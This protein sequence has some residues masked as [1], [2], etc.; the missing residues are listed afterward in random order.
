MK[1]L[2]A[3]VAAL[4]VGA[5]VASAQVPRVLSYQGIL[6]DSQGRILPDGEYTL[7]I[8]LYDRVD[9][10]EPIYV[11]EQRVVSVRGVVNV[12]IGTVEPLPWKLSFDR[13]YYV[14]MSVNGSEELRPRTMLTAVPYALRAE[15]AAVADVAKTVSPEA[16]KGVQIQATPDGPAGGDLTGTYP[17]PYI[18][19]NKVTTGKIATAAVTTDKIAPAA[20]TAAKLNQMGA[21]T[22]EYLR[23]NGTQWDP[24]PVSTDAWALVGNA[25]TSSNFLGTTNAQP[26]A[27][28]TNNL[29]RMR[30]DAS[31]NV[32]IGTT[33]PS[34]R[35]H[36]TATSNPV[37]IEGLGTDNTLDNV[38]V[39]DANGV[40]K[41][42][43]ATSLSGTIGWSLTGNSGTNPS[44]NFLGTTDGVD[45]AVRT[46]NT[47]R[48]RVTS[49]GYVGI[50]TT[51]PSVMLDVSGDANIAGNNTV[52]GNISVSGNATI[53]GNLSTNGNA[54][55]GDASSDVL[56]VNAQIASSLIP[57]T[58]N[59]FDLG[60]NLLRWRNGWFSGTVT[61][62]GLTLVGFTPGSVL[63]IGTGGALSQ[64]NANF[65]WDNT[66]VRLGIGTNTPSAN[67]HV[68]GNATVTTNTSIG[69]NLS[70][71]GNA[72]I[73][74]N[75][76]LGD[77]TTDNVT[78]TA[79]VNSHIHPSTD[80]TYDLGASTLRW[81]DGWFSG[82][83]TSQNATVTSLTPG[84]VVFAGTGGALSQNNAN[85]FW[86]N[87]N[88][89]LGIG[90]AT[91]AYP[92]HVHAPT[93]NA[94]NVTSTGTT[95]AG[96][97]FD[98]NSSGGRRF[99]I[100][101]TGTGAGVGANKLGFF[102]ETG[103]Y[104]IAVME[105]T[106]GNVGI[107]PSAITGPQARLHVD[108]GAIAVTNSGT[109]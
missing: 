84:S 42:R 93:H 106:T 77:A 102:D 22:G 71:A 97:R 43:T 37:R 30:I 17:N 64:N 68:V 50:G 57:T 72:N 88:V 39:V 98:A 16:L 44:T 6:T 38:L 81:K 69:G 107:G 96:I 56:T 14:G 89:R 85:F 78:F 99:S 12:L 32:G 104:Y 108:G 28:R 92:L 79:R 55:L 109:P 15:S 100:L 70:V 53:S 5:V 76:T 45:L 34:N 31:G 67:L 101:A 13:V 4:V 46:N 60:T 82:T 73:N 61:A 40:M 66:N 59:A 9:A 7:T 58:T 20:V 49:S 94:I 24:S 63:F 1:R 36:V 25:A 51:T 19:N 26:L 27:I 23:W 2:L 86:D 91:P 18:G 105:G 75:T 47:E 21:A 10:T 62:S 48:L 41:I 90:T 80:A 35:L 33:T 11:E 54:T 74:G 65:F 52:G 8:R 83:V 3:V 95:G 103:G 87:T 29:E